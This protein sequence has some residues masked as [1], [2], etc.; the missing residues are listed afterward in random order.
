MKKFITALLVVAAFGAYASEAGDSIGS[1][2][3]LDEIVVMGQSAQQRLRNVRLGV[4]NIELQS[5]LA[6]PSTFGEN[7]L[8]KS[9]SLMPGVRSEGEASSG[10]EVRGGTA[11]QNLVMLN[12]MTLYNPSHVAG[13]FSMFNDD[14][15]GKATLYKGPV[16]VAFGN[17]S[18]AVLEVGLAP[19]DT[20]RYDASATIGLLASKIAV[21]GPIVK[22]RLSFAVAAR[23]S[24]FDTFL[25]LSEEYKSTILHFYDVTADMRLKVGRTDYIDA[26]FVVSRDNMALK[27]L[28][29]MEWGN[30]GGTINYAA[31][32]SEKLTFL[33]TLALTH[34]DPDM[35]MEMAGE[36]KR[37]NQYI[38]TYSLNEKAAIIINDKFDLEAGLRSELLMVRSCELELNDNLLRE[39]R[40]GWQ[41]ALW[42]NAN[43]RI[44]TRFEF[45]AGVR[46]SA[47]STL[48]G[49]RFHDFVAP[50][51]TS[52]A[53]GSRTYIGF[54]PRGSLKFN[55]S[56]LHNIKL[57]A[58]ISTQNIHALRGSTS[59]FPFDR[60]ALTSDGSVRPERA[61]H[62]GI[63]YTGATPAGD[64]DWSVEGYFRDMKNVYDYI[65]GKSM[66]SAISLESIILSGRGRS[67]GAEFMLRKNAGSVTGWIAYTQSK[68]QTRI[69]G[70]NGGRWYDSTNDRRHDI[71]VA[72]IWRINDKW[73]LSAAWTYLTGTPI[74]APEAKYEINDKT[75][76]YHRERNAYRIPS[77]HKL[78]I[79]A[80]R[81][82]KHRRFSSQ[83]DFGIT[84][85]YWH[86]NPFVVRFV[87]DPDEPSGTRA[88]QTSLYGFLPSVS[89]TLKF[90]Q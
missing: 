55:L 44:G 22:D 16:P 15:V 38:H 26:A 14:A 1:V 31:H 18:S 74:T 62:Y 10:F 17:A 52:P 6:M 41:N 71:A 21:S 67:Y 81:T 83:L 73:R 69:S 80:T 90:K 45:S 79:G 32:P 8:L 25:K 27:D 4:E 37:M 28:M 76:Y 34:Y 72:A 60:Y 63:G 64:F 13:I 75:C 61:V 5:L 46:L 23:R 11:W 59:S 33:T 42:L 82:W 70:I 56:P 47:F 35:G 54:E 30:I 49:R 53:F 89:Y 58:G 88:V 77:S 36:E 9:L 57:G 24:Y 78:D 84:N 29:G 3:T 86:Y 20:E 50:N 40:S 7:D 12:G 87:D 48:S 68:T 66:F 2:E 51:E 65:D 39:E 43:G 19:G 85:V